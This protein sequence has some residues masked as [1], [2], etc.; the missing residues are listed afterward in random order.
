[1]NLMIFIKNKGLFRL[2]KSKEIFNFICGI[3]Y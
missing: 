3:V 1:M 2:G